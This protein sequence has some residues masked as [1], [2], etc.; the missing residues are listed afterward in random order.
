[1]IEAGALAGLFAIVL[2]FHALAS[3]F[4]RRIR[5]LEAAA[6]RI[7]DGHFDQVIVDRGL[8]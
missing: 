2:G 4:A 3:L 8:G 1:M 6:E 5:R 7:A